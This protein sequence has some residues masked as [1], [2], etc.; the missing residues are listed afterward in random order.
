M[1]SITIRNLPDQTKESLRV[2]AAQSGISLEAHARQI[3]VEASK[4]GDSKST[5]LVELAQ[6]YFGKKHGIDLTLP[7]RGSHRQSPEFDR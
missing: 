6:R 1:A 3:L 5:N 4:E 7:E 2:Q